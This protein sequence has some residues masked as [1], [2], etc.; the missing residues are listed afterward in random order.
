MSM[1]ERVAESLWQAVSIRAA[2]RTRLVSW[3]DEA[4]AT[5]EEWR[6]LARAAIGAMRQPSIPMIEAAVAYSFACGFDRPV[7]TP[8]AHWAIQY[9][10][11]IAAALGEPEQEGRAAGLPDAVIGGGTP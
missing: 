4:D 8:T 2:G 1:V 7:W 9:R 6:A 10:R 3:N 11:A 5:R